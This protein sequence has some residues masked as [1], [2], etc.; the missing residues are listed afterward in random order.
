MVQTIEIEGSI[1]S[2]NRGKIKF[3]NSFDMAQIVRF[4]EISP[5]SP[6]IIRGWQGHKIEKKWF[7]CHSGAFVIN[8]VNI[9]EENI[10][11]AELS[12]ERFELNES[13]P[14]ILEVPAGSASGFK[15][16]LPGSKLMVFSNFTLEESTKDDIRFPL[17][18]WNAEW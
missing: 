14:I 5:A 18:T 16:I 10:A 9:A 13:M 3:F 1:F 6:E 12:A 4:Y 7:Y 8:I 15:A 11:L 17:E 2:D